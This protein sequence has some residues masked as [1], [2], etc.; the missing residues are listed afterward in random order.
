M[1]TFYI[2]KVKGQ[3]HCDDIMFYR[4]TF[5]AVIQHHNSGTEGEIVTIFDICS[6]T[7]SLTLDLLCSQV[8]N[9]CEASMF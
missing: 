6:D 4:N 9:V 1:V 2:Q 5:L 7:E 3:L 8:E